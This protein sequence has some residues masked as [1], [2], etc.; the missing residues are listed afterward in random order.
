MRIIR[1]ILTAFA[2]AA[3][4][5]SGAS[6]QD[7]PAA[8]ATGGTESFET[9]NKE[10]HAAQDA[11]VAEERTAWEEAKKNRKEKDF[12]MKQP[13]GLVFSPRFLAIAEKNPKGPEAIDA[14]R[15]TLQ[16]SDGLKR[17]AP[18][19][20]RG[21]AVKI[22]R[23]YYVM[24]PTIKVC[25][26]MLANYDDA[27]SRALVAD[28]IARN[29]DRKVHVAV[30]QKQ[31]AIRELYAG[32]AKIAKDPK[33]LE[34]IVKA[35]GKEFVKERLKLADKAKTELIALKKTLR[36]KYG[37]LVSDLSVGNVA[38]EVSIQTVDGTEMRLSALR[39][40]V[41]VLDVWATWCGPCKAMIPH[42]RELVERLKDKPF[43][44]VS[45]SA[46]EQKETLTGFLAK[47][48]MPWTQCWVGVD[49]EFAGD[50]D[51][52]HYP[53]IYVI[54]AN[55]VIRDKGLEERGDDAKT[56]AELDKAVNALL[57][58]GKTKPDA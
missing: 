7:K 8:L 1:P 50:W 25:I 22:L 31:I 36:E 15:M 21:K 18:L 5:G 26:G 49:S 2:F 37:D 17:D 45:I 58:E 48:N 35:S 23:D 43:A 27:D 55:G 34:A 10:F 51:I 14:L 40:K 41:V 16:T 29:P 30:Y 52:R 56:D 20:T 32:F 44:M 47:N 38:P 4:S 9:I 39:G 57:A 54:D 46:D 13:P 24:D 19:E 28:V 33:R 12:K 6:A 11:W 42:S 3:V 53:T